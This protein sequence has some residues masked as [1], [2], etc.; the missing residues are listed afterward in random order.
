MED[1]K[2]TIYIMAALTQNEEK[3]AERCNI[4]WE[5]TKD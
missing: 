4:L 1:N 2:N 3:I 5:D